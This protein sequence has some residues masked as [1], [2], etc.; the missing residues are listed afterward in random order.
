MSLRSYIKSFT[1]SRWD[2]GI[3]TTSLS[4]IM[5]GSDITVR[6]IK[7]N[8]KDS[9]FAD[10][11]I[12]DV[13]DK[14]IVLLVEEFYKPINRGRLARIEVDAVSYEIITKDVILEL[15]THLSFPFFERAADIIYV[16]PE[17]SESGKWAR[18]V[19][20]DEKRKCVKDN[21]VIARPL[22]DA[23]LTYFFG[24]PLVFSTSMPNPNGNQLEIYAK[25]TSGFELCK[26]INF[27]ENVAR[28]S[29]A[30]FKYGGRIY[31]PTQECNVQYGHAVTIQEVL[32]YEDGF[33]FKEVRRLYSVHPKYQVGMHTFNVHNNLIAT[34]ALTFDNLWLRKILM[35]FGLIPKR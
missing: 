3:I 10:P 1:S 26:T 27:K 34:D 7:H 20:D 12:L 18:Y 6:W 23:V 17:N 33:M 24:E 30:F 16:Y 5:N 25:T 13:D 22:A 9:W 21:V 2:I 14:K 19:Y 32:K 31:R 11:F 8:F 28:M 15:D 29:G 4:D 35:K